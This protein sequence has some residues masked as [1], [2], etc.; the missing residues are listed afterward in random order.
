MA[1]L[2]TQ[3]LI[4][5]YYGSME[6]DQQLKYSEVR[7][8]TLGVRRSTWKAFLRQLRLHAAGLSVIDQMSSEYYQDLPEHIFTRG[9][10]KAWAVLE[11]N[12]MKCCTA[13]CAGDKDLA[14][15]NVAKIKR[16]VKAPVAR[17]SLQ[18]I[19]AFLKGRFTF[20]SCLG[21]LE[22]EPELVKARLKILFKDV[23]VTEATIKSLQQEMPGPGGVEEGRGPVVTEEDY[24]D[25]G[26]EA[27][28]KLVS[29]PPEAAPSV[30]G[31]SEQAERYWW[32]HFGYEQKHGRPEKEQ[33]LQQLEEVGL[34]SGGAKRRSY[35]EPSPSPSGS[36][37]SSASASS[38]ESQGA[39]RRRRSKR[40]ERLAGKEEDK[41][42]SF[43]MFVNNYVKQ[44]NG[45]IKD[46]SQ[47]QEPAALSQECS[48]F[49]SDSKSIRALLERN[50]T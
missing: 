43:R 3:H 32:D 8:P 39:G 50:L 38:R 22:E 31:Y 45:L 48:I 28:E 49:L 27:L 18:E 47:S 13:L 24:D 17:F 5:N 10:R 41:L 26:D 19:F 34:A 6:K 30:P 42:C 12:L 2:T 20:S 4:L 25:D 21:L 46:S 9:S 29:L 1:R 44:C 23:N 33:E 11:K 40:V 7:S 16:E 14:R 37:S 15:N 35:R 36:S